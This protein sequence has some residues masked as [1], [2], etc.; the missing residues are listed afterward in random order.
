MK[1][2]ILIGLSAAAL[3][4]MLLI[5]VAAPEFPR[6]NPILFWGIFLFGV[7]RLISWLA[8][9]SEEKKVEQ[10]I[11]AAQQETE[12]VAEATGQ[13]P[14]SVWVYRMPS[15]IGKLAPIEVFCD[16]KGIASLDNR[17]CALCKVLPG[18]HVFSSLVSRTPIRLTL[19]TGQEYFIRTGFTGLGS[20]AFETVPKPQA[21]LEI[22]KL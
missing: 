12:R 11:L 16:G 14:A 3:V 18:E 1:H 7:V 21:D 22:S 9:S 6:D 4:G 17:G 2:P 5:L 8:S 19:E 10:G 15:F 20:G 13:T